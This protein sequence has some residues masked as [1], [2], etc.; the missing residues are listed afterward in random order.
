MGK[1]VLFCN[2]SSKIEFCPLY[3]IHLAL[4]LIYCFFSFSFIYLL[5]QFNVNVKISF[6]LFFF[7]SFFGWDSTLLSKSLS[8]FFFLPYIF[9]RGRMGLNGNMK[10]VIGLFF[11]PPPFFF[12]DLNANRKIFLFFERVLVGIWISLGI[13][14]PK[15]PAVHTHRLR[16]QQQLCQCNLILPYHQYQVT[17]FCEC[18]R[19]IPWKRK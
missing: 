18:S 10:I 4:L 5:T 13:T 19:F 12:T 7:F 14:S 16:L 11:L 8:I 1:F 3:I 17:G 6:N 9:F 15:S 2:I